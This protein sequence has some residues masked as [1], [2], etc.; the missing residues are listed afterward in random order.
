MLRHD[1]TPGC[2]ALNCNT[3]RENRLL[4]SACEFHRAIV[5]TLSTCAIMFQEGKKIAQHRDPLQ[6]AFTLG[7]PLSNLNMCVLNHKIRAMWH[8]PS[9]QCAGNSRTGAICLQHDVGRLSSIVESIS[10]CN[11]QSTN[12]SGGIETVTCLNGHVVVTHQA[13]LQYSVFERLVATRSV[14]G[15]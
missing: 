7:D 6:F 12:T 10:C 14:V 15:R 5:E 2:R 9:L 4:P 8:H 1:Q 11:A 13:I 3:E